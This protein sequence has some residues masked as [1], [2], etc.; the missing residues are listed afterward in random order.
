[1]G[2]HHGWSG[3]RENVGNSLYCSFCGENK[4]KQCS[5]KCSEERDL[6]PAADGNGVDRRALLFHISGDG[7]TKRVMTILEIEVSS[8]TVKEEASI[9]P[10]PLQPKCPTSNTF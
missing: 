9:F 1:M 6:Y 10:F 2:K 4:G 5:Q 3:G 7:L 8:L